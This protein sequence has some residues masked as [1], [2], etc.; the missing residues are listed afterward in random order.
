MKKKLLKKST[1]IG[2]LC[3]YDGID[4]EIWEKGVVENVA[5]I[6][7]RTFNDFAN[8]T[9]LDNNTGVYYETWTVLNPES[10]SLW[11]DSYD[12]ANWVLR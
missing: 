4:H 5:N 2:A 12:C 3:V 10:N 1:F 6:T 7:G 11:F 8:W 9:V